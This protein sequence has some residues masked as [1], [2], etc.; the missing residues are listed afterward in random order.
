V[1]GWRVGDPVGNDRYV[2]STEGEIND[3]GVANPS[4]DGSGGVDSNRFG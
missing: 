4:E 1:A 3:G 2:P